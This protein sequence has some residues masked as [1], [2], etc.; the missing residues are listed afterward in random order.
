MTKLSPIAHHGLTAEIQNA[1]AKLQL[2]AADTPNFLKILAQSLASLRA[3]SAAEHALA[4]GRLTALQR[5]QVALAVAEINGAPYC[6][7]ANIV[8]ARESGLCDAEID[9]AR[10]AASSDP[11]SHALL[12]FTQAVV[13]QRGEI[14]DADLRSVHRAGFSD[15]EIV[16]IIGNIA[17]NI[18]T[19]YL[20]LI[21]KTEAAISPPPRVPRAPALAEPVK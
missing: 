17:I 7:A 3:Y 14:K 2:K 9:L 5:R 4:K 10:Q 8:R 19:N 1:L 11:A 18:F 16:E 20:N 12:Q 13:L 21:A 15:S 6:V